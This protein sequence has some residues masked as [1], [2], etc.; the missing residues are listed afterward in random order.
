MYYVT[1]KTATTKETVLIA[2]K[3]NAE[4]LCNE[5]LKCQDVYAVEMLSAETGELL[6]YKAK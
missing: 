1:A 3:E 4:N 5:Y 6:Y 2:I